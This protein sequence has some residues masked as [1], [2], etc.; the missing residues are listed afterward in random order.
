M[1]QTNPKKAILQIQAGAGGVDA[2]DWASML[3]RM[4]QRFAESQG[5]QLVKI[6]HSIGEQQGTKSVTVEIKG[7]GVYDRLKG[8]SGVHRLVRIS[9]YSTKKLR[10]TSFALVEVLPSI[11]PNRNININQGDLRIDT[12][13]SGGPG[14]QHVNKTESAIRITHIPTGLVS[15]CQSERSQ[16]QNREKAMNLLMSQLQYR[17]DQEHKERVEDLKTQTKI[18]WGSQIRSYVLHPY[19]KV[20]DHRSNTEDNQAEAVL[21]GKLDKFIK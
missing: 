13:R 18:E 20:K 14:G 15:S 4:Y 6:S 5:W 21:D 2:Q 8:E 11:I 7:E 1:F 3:L 12:F 19:K 10:H 17:M 9:P 16:G